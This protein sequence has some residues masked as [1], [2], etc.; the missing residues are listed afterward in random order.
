[1]AI[2]LLHRK[3]YE[4]EEKRQSFYR[5]MLVAALLGAVIYFIGPKWLFNALETRA[6]TRIDFLQGEINKN[7]QALQAIR[8]EEEKLKNLMAI[9]SD[10]QSISLQR[11]AIVMLFN[12]LAIIT[13]ENT[14][15]TRIKYQ[16]TRHVTIEGMAPSPT[17]VAAIM[18]NIKAS[19]TFRNAFLVASSKS[20]QDQRYH[21][22]IEADLL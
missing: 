15:L 1:M 10:V 22:I 5:M 2:D 14:R 21:F 17:Q 8:T 12:E 20:S 6:Q 7:R 19:V 13:P 18:D 3:S 4:P 9:A 16:K 11:Q